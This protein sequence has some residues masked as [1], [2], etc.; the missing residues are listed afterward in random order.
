MAQQ[1]IKQLFKNVN[2]GAQL[3]PSYNNLILFGYKDLFIYH[4]LS[5]S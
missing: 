1:L 5:L 2:I 3:Y 4:K